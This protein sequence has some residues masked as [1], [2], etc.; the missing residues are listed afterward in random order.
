MRAVAPPD[1]G[2]R[3]F[4]KMSFRGAKRRGN[5]FP[6]CGGGAVRH[7]RG[8]GEIGE[9][10]PAADEASRFR[11]SAPIGGHDS[12]RESAGTT[13]GSRRPLRPEWWAVRRGYGCPCCGA[14]NFRAALRRPLKILTA[15]TRSSRFFCHRQRSI[16]SPHQRARWFAMTGNFF[17]SAVRIGRRHTR[18]PPYRD[19]WFFL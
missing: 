3:F 5:P 2:H 4:I 17:G 18:V 6:L 12:G 9:A 10:P 7:R 8:V 14:Q 13:V 19:F 15:A 16:R 11:G 1:D